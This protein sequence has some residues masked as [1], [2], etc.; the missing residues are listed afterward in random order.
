MVNVE[1]ALSDL[2]LRIND[3]R[4]GAAEAIDRPGVAAFLP[5]VPHAGSSGFRYVGT[6]RA[7]DLEGLNEVVIAG[8]LPDGREC[9]LE[10]LFDP[11]AR[12]LLPEAPPELMQRTVHNA[13]PNHNLCLA[14]QSYR[15]FWSGITRYKESHEVRRMLDWGCGCGRLAGPLLLYSGVPE[16][17]GCDIDAQGVAWCQEN[18]AGGEF[19]TISPY[20]PTDYHTATF[21]VIVSYSV[22]THLTRDVQN[23]W[24]GEMQRLLMPRGLFL[25]SVHGEFAARFAQFPKE[26][27]A[28]FEQEGFYDGIHDETL[29]GIAPSGYYRATFQTRSY[30][31]R[32]WSR[33]FE[34]LDYLEGGA[35]NFQDMIVMRKR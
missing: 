12:G 16:L 17:H 35:L 33:Y 26:I 13:D 29:E 18:L 20:P 7:E 19:R 2:E 15:E 32:E 6:H 34:I 4:V 8:R 14:M 30:T 3:E 25:A 28:R 10:T 11:A 22:F 1:S 21:D 9:R 31:E 5:H 23:Q 27:A 24:L